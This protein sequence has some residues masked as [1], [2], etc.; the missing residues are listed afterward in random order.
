MGYLLGGHRLRKLARKRTV[1]G[2]LVVERNNEAENIVFVKHGLGVRVYLDVAVE[3]PNAGL[4]G[5]G[6]R[7]VARTLEL[8]VQILANCEKRVDS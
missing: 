8:D 3:V 7:P 1:G 5:V 2:I 4:E 6:L